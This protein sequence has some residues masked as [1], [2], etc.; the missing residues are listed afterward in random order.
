MDKLK[1]P[2]L[3][4]DILLVFTTL[5]CALVTGFILTFAVVVMPD[6]A[7][8]GDRDFI[9][10]FQVTDGVI[11][12][13]QPVFSSIWIGS[14]IA[15]VGLLI[16]SIAD[17]VQ[18]YDRRKNQNGSLPRMWQNRSKAKLTPLRFRAQ[19]RNRAFLTE[20]L[21]RIGSLPGMWQTAVLTFMMN[22]G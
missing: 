14:V 19:W 10:A 20:I 16:A 2:M 4:F 7:S 3:L 21:R 15:T 1:G 8:L 22:V 6:L 17:T 5:T 13:G 18:R 12:R 9:R 11:Q